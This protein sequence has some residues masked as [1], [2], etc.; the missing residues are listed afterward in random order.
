MKKF[1]IIYLPPDWFIE[2]IA[3]GFDDLIAYALQGT[4]F[5][6]KATLEIKR[7]DGNEAIITKEVFDKIKEKF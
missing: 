2:Q 4:G 3:I 6:Q 5:H 1:K 7:A